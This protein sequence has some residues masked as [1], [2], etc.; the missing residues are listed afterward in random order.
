MAR[1]TISLPDDLKERMDAV[2]EPVN[3]S[4][5]AAR[6]FETRL[7]EIASR[8]RGKDMDSVIQ[9]LRASKVA[10]EDSDTKEGREAGERWAQHDAEWSELERLDRAL[11][12][13]SFWIEGIEEQDWARVVYLAM[14]ND[15]CSS[16][17]DIEEFWGEDVEVHSSRAWF[18]G[19]CDGAI[20]VFD[21]VRD[22]V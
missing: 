9:R 2:K 19:F 3:W 8:A 5:V 18:Q 15:E 21:E 14:G 17:S 16:R 1:T 22:K 20:A 11:R 7:G 10:C 4:Q 12:D 13:D 6:A